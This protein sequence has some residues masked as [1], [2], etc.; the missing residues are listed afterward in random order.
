QYTYVDN[1]SNRLLTVDFGKGT[2][3]EGF[4]AKGNFEERFPGVENPWSGADAS[5]PY[6]QKFY[7]VMN[8]AVGGVSGFFPDGLGG[9]MWNNKDSDAAMKF[10]E[11]TSQW[12]PTWDGKN[13]ALQVR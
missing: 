4:W 2:D 11:A 5:A 12:F 7:V 10:L 9:K 8:V 3:E 13:S 6:D 1:D